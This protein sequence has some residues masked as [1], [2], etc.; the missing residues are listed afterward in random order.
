MLAVD[1]T[2]P[3][4]SLI[5]SFKEDGCSIFFGTLDADHLRFADEVAFALHSSNSLA[6]GILHRRMG[7]EDDRLAGAIGARRCCDRC[8]MDSSEMWFSAMRV[9][10]LAKTPVRSS[11]VRRMK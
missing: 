4:A 8:T 10:M 11:T 9:A 7:D 2:A 1:E 5:S 3:A 6:H